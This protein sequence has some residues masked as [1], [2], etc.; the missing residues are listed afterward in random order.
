MRSL[1][2]TQDGMTPMP[3]RMKRY[4]DRPAPPLALGHCPEPA[5]SGCP[6]RVVCRTRDIGNKGGLLLWGR[7]ET[8]AP[9]LPGLTARTTLRGLN[10]T[11]YLKAGQHASIEDLL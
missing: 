5:P 8:K 9:A 1:H 7:P 10:A 4:P 11:L 3:A 2:H 6:V